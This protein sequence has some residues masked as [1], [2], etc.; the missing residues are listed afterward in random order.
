MITLRELLTLG[1]LAVLIFSGIAYY[2]G[3]K[4]WALGV[5]VLL[6]IGMIGNLIEILKNKFQQSETN[7]NSIISTS[8]DSDDIDYEEDEVEEI[9][10]RNKYIDKI[11]FE[12]RTASGNEQIYTV[13]VY[14]GLRGNLEGWCIEREGIRTFL[15]ERIVNNEVTKLDT[16]EV[17]A[18]KDWRASF[19]KTKSI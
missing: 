1:P 4:G 12:Y 15:P 8:Y 7:S 11:Q 10:P 5:A 2:F 19:R 14:K 13:L 18:L 17:L 16:G 3:G 6:I 9:K